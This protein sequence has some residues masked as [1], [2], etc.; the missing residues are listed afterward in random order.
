M[1]SQYGLIVVWAV[2]IASV[3]VG[4]FFLKFGSW[5]MSDDPGDWA[6]FATYLSGTVGVTAVV[7]T[8]FAF[9]IT[10]SQQKELVKSQNLM[11]QEQKREIDLSE[12][13]LQEAKNKDERDMSYS[14]MRDVL[15]LMLKGFDRSL[16][17]MFEPP[18]GSCPREDLDT[19]IGDELRSYQLQYVVRGLGRLHLRLSN[20]DVDKKEYESYINKV[21]GN[22]RHL[23]EFLVDN[24]RKN[25]A[26]FY[27][28][29]AM[30]SDRA[31]SGSWSYWQYI[32]CYLAYGSGIDSD[33]QKNGYCKVLHKKIN[34]EHCEDSTLEYLF[35]IGR[36]LRD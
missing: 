27:V 25:P 20:G 3:F 7:G 9:V 34:Y 31:G 13:Q 19:Y 22:S 17:L 15:P 12:E 10:L 23:T 33:F 5:P 1:R 4:A 36:L 8:L 14:N 2:V 16:N 24:I 18:V 35:K 30:L 28:A 21:L 32:E 26:L 29:D 11:L 6:D